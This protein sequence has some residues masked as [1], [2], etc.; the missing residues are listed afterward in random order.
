MQALDVE[1]GLAFL[2]VGLRLEQVDPLLGVAVAQAK[3]LVYSVVPHVRLVE[4][5]LFPEAASPAQLRRQ[6]RPKIRRKL[7]V[8]SLV[9][10]VARLQVQPV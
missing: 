10:R 8:V 9:T 4:V 7:L 5:E 6:V 1:H 3:L 2:E